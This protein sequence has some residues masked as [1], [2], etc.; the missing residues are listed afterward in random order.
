MGPGAPGSWSP[1]DAI[2]FAWNRIKADPGTILG[3][4]FVGWLCSAA[5]SIIGGVIASIVSVAAS[6]GSDSFDLVDMTIRG[7]SS[8]I[9]YIVQAFMMAGMMSFSLKVARGQPYAFGDIFSGG[10]WFLP[11]LA[12]N[13]CIAI[14]VTIGMFCLI[15]P[16][17]FLALALALSVPLAVDKN[18]GPIEAMSESWRA[19]QGQKGQ[20]FVFGLF[21]F[22]MVL[23]G[24]CA[25][26]LGA[27]VAGA[28]AQ[29][30]WAWAYL[31]ITGQQTAA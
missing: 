30:A 2:A 1:Q 13:F 16:G 20:I 27:F 23:L 19:T 28:I 9:G 7:G 4:L 17:I 14:G 11:V 18:L 3:A 22:G 25:C 15:A 21:I 8:F 6:S 29:V 10:T 31:R 26:G 24:L 5:F 12:V